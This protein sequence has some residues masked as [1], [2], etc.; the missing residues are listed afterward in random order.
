MR[1]LKHERMQPGDDEELRCSYMLPNT[2]EPCNYK[3]IEGSIYCQQHQ[4]PTA[5]RARRERVRKYQLGQ[6]Q[7]R[8]IEFAD[9]GEIKTLRDE[10]ALSRL[11]LET[12][13]N[14]LQRDSENQD[15][16]TG[17]LAHSDVIMR[18]IA[19][20]E[21][22]V[23]N[24]QRLEEKANMQLSIDQVFGLANS[25]IDIIESIPRLTEDDKQTIVIKIQTAILGIQNESSQPKILA[26]D[27]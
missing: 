19:R 17:F 21:S 25:F 23:V 1:Q 10:I 16:A 12:V 14:K 3:M 22:L 15:F 6:L 27:I 4:G 20:I 5:S 9:D 26:E 8:Y 2:N 11:G 24:C 7:N 18:I 13:L